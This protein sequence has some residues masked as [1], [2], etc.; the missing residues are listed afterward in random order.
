MTALVVARPL[1]AGEDPGRLHSAEASSGQILNLLWLVVALAGGVWLARAPRRFRLG[2]PVALGLMGVALLVLLSAVACNGYRYPAWLIACEWAVLPVVF[3]LTR[4]LTPD[5]DPQSD[6]AGGLLAAMLATAVSVAAFGLYQGLAAAVH[7]RSPDL[8]VDAPPP[9]PPGDDFAAYWPKTADLDWIVRGTLERSDTLIGLLLLLI[10]ITVAFC[11]GGRGPKARFA[12][13]A[14]LVLVVGFV[15]A[16]RDVASSRYAGLVRDGW[17]TALKMTGERPLLGVGPGN[18]DRHTARL[19]PVDR[20]ELLTEAWGTYPELLATCGVPALLAF[21]ALTGYTVWRVHRMNEPEALATEDNK[22]PVAN[23]SGSSNLD[24]A[25][26][27]EFYLGG[28]VGLLLGLSLRVL[29]LPG[30]E[31]PQAILSAGGGGVGRALVWFLAFAVFEGGRWNFAARRT[32]LLAGLILLLL[33]GLVSGALLRPALLQLFWVVAGLALAGGTVAEPD[34][35]STRAVRWAPVP[36][37]LAAALAF[38]LLVCSP[39]VES[40]FATY[41]AC[42]AES[43][44]LEK[45]LYEDVVTSPSRSPGEYQERL[46]RANQFLTRKILP[47]LE[48]AA[49][50]DPG[51]AGRRLEL[52]AWERVRESLDVPRKPDVPLA[53]LA[54]AERLDPA[55]AGPLL[56]DYLTRLAFAGFRLRGGARPTD[57]QAGNVRRLR[58]EQ[59]RAAEELIPAI[60]ARDPALEA[61]LKFR[62]AQVLVEAKGDPQTKRGRGIA[63]EALRLDE[64]APGPRWRLTDAQRELA[65]KWA[66]P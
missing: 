27:W 64:D 52:A 54:D 44:F 16:L 31:R 6:S 2:G 4:E 35:T 21:L 51:D 45:E 15:L 28:V 22:T 61:R 39:A 38:Y 29:D 43:A 11:R 60:L 63:A 40:A 56:H 47:P 57:T 5:A 41:H 32:A 42:V 55:N 8:P 37:L 10:P 18:F 62:L 59:L 48:V 7:L 30:T 36:V 66:N 58:V 17:T 49:L 13:V 14:L 50:A 20:P 65:R 12:L 19:Q 1:V 53:A 33:F 3:A 23:A 46:D 25:P 34:T 26:R 24:L 9:V